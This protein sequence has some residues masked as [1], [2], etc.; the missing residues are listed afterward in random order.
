MVEA[1]LVVRARGEG[2]QLRS[3][4]PGLREEQP[5]LGR[6]GEVLAEQ[7]LEDRALRALGMRALRD[8][9]QLIRVSEQDERPGRGRRREHVR[10]RQLPGLVDHQRVER[11]LRGVDVDRGPR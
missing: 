1:P 11:V 7:V 4:P 3:Q 5:S 6:H 9:W 2:A 10:E 8:L